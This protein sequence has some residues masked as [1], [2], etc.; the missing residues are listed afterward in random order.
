MLKELKNPW[1]W[2]G[3]VLI[4]LALT[5]TGGCKC[6]IHIKSN[7]TQVQEENRI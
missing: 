7:N 6:S 4:G 3:V 5:D 1:L 2:L